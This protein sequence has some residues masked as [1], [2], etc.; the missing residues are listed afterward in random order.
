MEQYLEFAGNH[1]FLIGAFALVLAM[2]V[3]TETRRFAGGYQRVSPNDAVRLI[4]DGDTLLLD[5]REDAEL[6][7]GMIDGAKHIPLGNLAKRIGELD[8]HKTKNILAYCR[9][10]SRSAQACGILRKNEFEKVH[11]LSG[12]LMAWQSANLPVKRRR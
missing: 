7:Q 1:P 6:Q 4:N 9:T 12:G 11:N 5:V 8:K 3:W 10:G 2:I